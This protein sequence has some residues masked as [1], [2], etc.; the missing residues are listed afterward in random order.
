MTLYFQPSTALRPSILS[1][2]QYDYIG[3]H[4]AFKPL[5]MDPNTNPGPIL[6][7]KFNSE[8]LE[9]V[10]RLCLPRPL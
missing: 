1:P 9:S 2:P 5:M 10:F 6:P 4:P 8:D 7:P 3:P